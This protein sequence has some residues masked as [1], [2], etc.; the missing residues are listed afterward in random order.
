MIKKTSMLEEKYPHIFTLCQNVLQC[1]LYQAS[2]LKQLAT[3][4]KKVLI[5][6]G[7]GATVL[8]VQVLSLADRTQSLG[9][10]T[11]ASSIRASRAV[12]DKCYIT[13]IIKIRA[14]WMN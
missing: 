2:N 10:P 7:G 13:Y 3:R 8:H 11:V 1:R 12:Y 4:R 5:R 14:I 6:S 9:H